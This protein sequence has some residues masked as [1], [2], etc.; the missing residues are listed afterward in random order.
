MHDRRRL[1]GR[2][3]AL[4]GL[5]IGLGGSLRSQTP[6]LWGDLTAGRFAVG[7]RSVSV[8][9]DSRVFR[10]E[11]RADGSPVPGDRS[12]PV[13]ISYWYPS[14]APKRGGRMN[15]GAYVA[16]IA[17]EENSG[18]PKGS[19]E[20][21]GK[22]L[23]ELSLERWLGEPPSD[24]HT[25][26]LMK[27]ETAAAMD[28]TPAQGTYPLVLLA[29]GSSQSAVTHAILCEYLA[30][31]GFIVVTVPSIGPMSR[32]MPS[33]ARGAEAQARDLEFALSKLRAMHVAARVG[34]GVIGFSFG[35]FA[36]LIESMRNPDVRV[37]ISLDSNLGFQGAAG[38]LAT[39]PDYAAARMRVPFLHFSQSDYPGLDEKLIDSLRYSDRTIIR[40]K[41]LTHF[42][43]SSLGMISTMIP[44]LV[45]TTRPGQRE[46]YE[47][48]CR[49]VLAFLEKH[50]ENSATAGEDFP[51][52]QRGLLT[53]R[54]EGAEPAAP[55]YEE[56]VDYIRM[57][58]V[59]G[60]RKLY[61][62]VKRS[63][64]RDTLCAEG[65]L[66]RMGYELLYAYRL[67]KEAIEVF[68]WNVEA[69]PGSF[70]V[71]DSLG[72][73]YLADGARDSAITNY[74]RSLELNPQNSNA[75]TVLERLGV[76]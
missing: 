12:R 3:I 30:S 10:P 48:V 21:V 40:V 9:D 71:Y 18:N 13:Q 64:P 47:S 19:E 56:F 11:K 76:K 49:Y 39:C 27:T 65:T 24:P 45:K 35:G 58:G 62:S 34:P 20:S 17:R 60:A 51:P 59:G 37:C 46:G 54:H 75:R 22:K 55:L 38:F 36:A 4:A 1:H 41:G 74:R 73:A 15:F 52:G 32:E 8:R 7:F 61:E 53:I 67:K 44:G 2:A 33:E 26:E 57:K 16:L 68:R 23:F 14:L 28:A 6:L 5:L 42:D 70:N 31:H 25:V 29:Q 43:F 66:N 50:M 63:S 69:Y 72:E